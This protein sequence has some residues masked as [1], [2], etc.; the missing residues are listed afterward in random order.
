MH[1]NR[2][3]TALN[4]VYWYGVRAAESE[5]LGLSTP[6]AGVT[7]V[8]AV[9]RKFP[10]AD[11]PRVPRAGAIFALHARKKRYKVRGVRQHVVGCGSAR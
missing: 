7:D 10:L 1:D 4:D 6:Y 9:A 8:R 2:G 3:L 11:D 5:D